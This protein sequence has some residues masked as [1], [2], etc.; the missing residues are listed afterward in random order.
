M[1]AL[2]TLSLAFPLAACDY[3]IYAVNQCQIPLTPLSGVTL[4]AGVLSYT[5]TYDDLEV[6]MIISDSEYS[7]GSYQRTENDGLVVNM[8]WSRD[9]D[10]TERFNS[11]TNEG[12]STAFVEFPDCSGNA[13][14]VLT[15]SNGEPGPTLSASWSSPTDSGFSGTFEWCDLVEGAI[16]CT[17]FTR[18]K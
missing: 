9:S 5:R 17:T 3:I 14:R 15:P 16:Q 12:A 18:P 11:T 10:G 8:S 4:N 6:K 1:R 7:S 13:T 2:E